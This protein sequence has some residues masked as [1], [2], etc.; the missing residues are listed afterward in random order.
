[1]LDRAHR[2]TTGTEFAT[3]VRRGRRAGTETLVVHLWA[4]GP[5]DGTP[6]SSAP[7]AP[8][9]VGLVVGRT[10]G[11]A[12][13]RNQVKRRLRH[14]VRPRL[15]AL[16]AGALLVVR[17]LPPAGTAPGPQLAD[18]LDTALTRVLRLKEGRR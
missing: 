4:P 6:D 18:D 16:P 12:V 8:P 3:A 1:M 2:L 15:D 7:P 11:D 13:A 5:D 9:R 14:L 17:A 10:V